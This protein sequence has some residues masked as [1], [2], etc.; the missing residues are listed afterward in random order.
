MG[1]PVACHFARFDIQTDN[2]YGNS[3]VIISIL[4]IKETTAKVPQI[5]NQ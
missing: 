3:P 1:D 2:L 5:I 4:K